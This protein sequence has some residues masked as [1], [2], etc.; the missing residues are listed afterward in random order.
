MDI[1]LIKKEKKNKNLI[2][3]NNDDGS[4]VLIMNFND[5]IQLNLNII[6]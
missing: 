4:Y 1:N 6:N 3:S 5:K 2:N